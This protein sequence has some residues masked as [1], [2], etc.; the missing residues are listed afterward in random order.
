METWMKIAWAIAIVL[1]IAL[2][3]PTAKHWLQHG[4]K[5]SANDWRAAL[6]PLAGVVIFVILLILMVRGF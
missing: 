2:I 6:L 5:G 1:I 4:P 3:W